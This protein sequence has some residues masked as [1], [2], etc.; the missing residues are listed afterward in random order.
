MKRCYSTLSVTLFSILLLCQ[1]YANL[2]LSIDS[3]FQS[4]S[5]RGR[6][7]TVTRAK[8]VANSLY[9]HV[10]SCRISNTDTEAAD[11]APACLLDKILPDIETVLKENVE[12][13]PQKSVE[14]IADALEDFGAYL[15]QVF[16]TSVD[17]SPLHDL[18]QSL[19]EEKTAEEAKR[20]FI[21]QSNLQTLRK[22]L[23]S[24]MLRTFGVTKQEAHSIKATLLRMGGQ[25]AELVEATTAA[26][27]NLVKY[28]DASA[29]QWAHIIVLARA[30]HH[31]SHAKEHARTTDEL[32]FLEMQ[33]TSQTRQRW[34]MIALLV[35]LLIANNNE[36]VAIVAGQLAIV[37]P[38]IVVSV[39]GNLVLLVVGEEPA[40]VDA[41][42][43]PFATAELAEAARDRD[44]ETSAESTHDCVVCL[45]HKANVRFD[46]GHLNMCSACA[47]NQMNM[48][49]HDR[50][51]LMCR[52]EV[53][54]FTHLPV[55]E[56]EADREAHP[57]TF[58]N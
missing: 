47:F 52:Q 32:A 20:K 29:G 17:P 9:A 58:I 28:N 36:N 53:Q 43:G 42:I 40:R 41:N 50:R 14:I 39:I 25:A 15:E 18:Y 44:D 4:F 24:A 3:Q 45:G 6:S 11:D 10:G 48:P 22:E 51:C 54:D 57:H 35:L 8:N 19:R 37:M 23:G 46:C 49:P 1:P 5:F 30:V 55:A 38:L 33:E 7:L 26:V 21:M 34:L 13:S 56:Y 12:L 2:G 16:H 31:S 27:E